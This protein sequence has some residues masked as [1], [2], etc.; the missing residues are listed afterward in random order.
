MQIRTGLGVSPGIAIGQAFILGS[1]DVRIPQRFIHPE[2]IDRE[3]EHLVEGL[4]GAKS[5]IRKLQERAVEVAPIFEAHVRILED[6]K[7]RRELEECIRTLRYTA[8]YAV[9]RVFRRY[10]RTLRAIDDYFLSQRD[11]D[12][13]DIERR[14]LRNLLGAQREDLAHLNTPVI[15][16]AKDLAPSQTASLDRSKVLAFVTEG[17]GR[18]S[19]T[20]IVARSLEI[21]AVVGVGELLGEVTGGDTIVADGN[22][23]KVIVAPDARTLKK[24]EQ[25]STEY[26][27]FE[28][29]L[30]ELRE[31]PAETTDG[32]RIRLLCNIEF[33]NEIPAALR[34]GAEG[35]GLYRTE[36]LFLK[37]NRIP[38]EDEH[39][40]AYMESVEALGGRPIVIRTF[41]LGGDKFAEVTGTPRERNPFLGCRSIRH[42]LE[43]PPMFHDQIRAI[44]RASAKG[45][46]K[47]LF[48]MITSVIELRKA[49][50][51]VRE[52]MD[53]LRSEGVP[54]DENMQVGALIEV[55]SAAICADL[56]AKEV[57]FF[58]VGTNDL[59]QYT[60][61][62]DRGN[63]R[64]S[65]L[66]S[67]TS[68]A[69]LRLLKNIFDVAADH[70]L[71]VTVCGEMSGH[72]RYT[73]LLLGL[74][75][76][77]F[78]VSPIALPEIK[79]VIRSVGIPESEEIARAVLDSDHSDEALE[80]LNNRTKDIIPEAFA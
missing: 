6:K 24:Y 64:V 62:V 80:E 14:V 51:I 45:D 37:E 56:I 70:D 48:P 74:G 68:P 15:I 20:A 79:K 54:F 72:V 16:V 61:A 73:I 1:E 43:N 28:E 66:Y 18:T 35:I 30:V 46:V 4:D 55:P 38:T 2:N 11:S 50:D 76:R 58:S 65:N 23:G 75:L 44:L 32:T 5:E 77:I 27:T 9:S 60:L 67:H 53:A 40:A 3:L 71:P 36:F 63:E 19:H 13:N 34:Q 22:S 59:V 78:S 12:I 10:A 42:C 25:A 29:S 47:L 8:E 7:L 41:D 39:T 49:R 21:P 69:V 33:P 57:D 17:G 52:E 26:H 31:Q